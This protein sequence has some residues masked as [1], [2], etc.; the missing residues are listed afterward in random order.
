MHTQIKTEAYVFTF[1][2]SHENNA[3]VLKQCLTTHELSLIFSAVM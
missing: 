1:Q 3:K 2:S